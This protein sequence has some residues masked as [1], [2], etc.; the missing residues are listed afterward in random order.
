MHSNKQITNIK[1]QLRHLDN[2][3]DRVSYAKWRS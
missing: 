3:T 1:Q 2:V